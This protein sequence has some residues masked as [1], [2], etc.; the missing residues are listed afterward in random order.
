MGK[1]FEMVH[2]DEGTGE[3]KL[4]QDVADVYP[5]ADLFLDASDSRVLAESAERAIRLVFGHPF[6][7]P[8][9]DESV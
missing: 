5:L 3:G 7:T 2:R 9:R 1:A 4:G 8:T 6:M